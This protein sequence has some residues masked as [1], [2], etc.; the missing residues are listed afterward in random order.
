MLELNIE[1]VIELIPIDIM[2][3]LL[4]LLDAFINNT[5]MKS[6]RKQK[7]LSDEVQNILKQVDD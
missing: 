3:Y 1:C 2:H 4:I 6:V 7:I 5:R